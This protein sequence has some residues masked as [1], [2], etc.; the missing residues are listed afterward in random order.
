MSLV[1]NQWIDH[2]G[3]ECPVPLR[4]FVDAEGT[5]PSGEYL[6]VSG[7]IEEFDLG[8]LTSWN[9]E[10][11]GKLKNIGNEV[12]ILG[13]IEKYRIHKPNGARACEDILTNLPAPS[14]AEVPA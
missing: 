12:H 7:P 3:T 11:F 2:D 10:C 6:S 9:W 14:P 13:R 8:P 5:S 4:Y 1:Y